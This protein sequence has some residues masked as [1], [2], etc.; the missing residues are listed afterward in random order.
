MTIGVDQPRDRLPVLLAD[1]LVAVRAHLSPLRE[2][3]LAP[4]AR[5]QGR[6]LAADVVADVDLP[7]WDSS[8]VDGFA[9]RAADLIPGQVVKLRLAGEALAGH[10]FEGIVDEGQ[11][12]RILTG[13]QLPRGADVVLMQETCEFDAGSVAV[14]SDGRSKT[15]WRRRGED[16]RV[17]SVV[18]PAGRRL[19]AQDVALA[20]AVGCRELTVHKQLHVGVFST[21]DELCEPGG[22]RASGQIW[23]ANR[24]LVRALIEQWAAWLSI[25]G[26]CATSLV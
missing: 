16:V 5:A 8:A 3:E 23:D 13:A 9:A 17:G 4:L 1:A 10:L 26:Y 2:R 12:V 15:H 11:A 18:L 19:R 25:A 22:A 6:I 24:C 20:G 14:C 21:G 7:P